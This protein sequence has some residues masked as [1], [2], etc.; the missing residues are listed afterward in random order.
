[1]LTRQLSRMDLNLLLT[2]Q[3]L[4]DC[5]S[6]YVA[7]RE[8]LREWLETAAGLFVREDFD[9]GSWKGE[10]MLVAHDNVHVTLVPRLLALLHDRAPGVTLKVQSQYSHQLNGLERG[11]IDFV[12]NLQLSNLP[13]EFR[14]EV[15]FEDEPVILARTGHPLR[16]KRWNR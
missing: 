8:P 3:V 2:L 13:A 4:L 5:H 15:M 7:A 11:E 16:Q 12:L 9:A 6:V 14:S 10:F 1:M